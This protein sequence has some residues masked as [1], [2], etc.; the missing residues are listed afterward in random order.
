[1]VIVL[2]C[3]T[4]SMKKEKEEEYL[5]LL[6]SKLVDGVIIAACGDGKEWIKILKNNKI[7]FC[8]D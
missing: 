1:M 8:Y 2:F 3:A 6:I 4:L 5:K 7:P